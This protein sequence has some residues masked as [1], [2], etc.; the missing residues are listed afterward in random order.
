MSNIVYL[1]SKH[2]DRN[3]RLRFVIKLVLNKGQSLVVGSSFPKIRAKEIQ[4]MFPEAQIEVM[5]Y[6]VKICG[7]KQ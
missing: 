1:A 7:K 5:N 6:G 3:E 2:F 4:D